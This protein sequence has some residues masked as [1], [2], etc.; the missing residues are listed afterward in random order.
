MEVGKRGEACAARHNSLTGL[1]DL[2]VNNIA[3]SL[4]VVAARWLI[5]LALHAGRG[6]RG[7]RRFFAWRVGKDVN[8]KY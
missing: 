5:E 7:R 3:Y 4:A 1:I 2:A 6:E 8:Q